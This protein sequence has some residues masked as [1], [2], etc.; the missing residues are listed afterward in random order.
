M[1]PSLSSL[2]SSSLSVP[3]CLCLSV[4]VCPSVSVS[5]CLS[6]CL[7]LSLFRSLYLSFSIFPFIYLPFYRHIVYL[8]DICISQLYKSFLHTDVNLTIPHHLSLPLRAPSLFLF[9]F[10]DSQ[11]CFWRSETPGLFLDL[12]SNTHS[13]IWIS[14]ASQ[15]QDGCFLRSYVQN[16]NVPSFN[17]QI[18]LKLRKSKHPDN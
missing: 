12:F 3:L 10:S 4:S 9:L 15:D 6:V 17:N 11:S 8:F 5:V 2:T 16:K 1:A 14:G 7:S 13:G 18:K